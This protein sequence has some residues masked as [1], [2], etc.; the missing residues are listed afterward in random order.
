MNRARKHH[1][2]V[3]VVEL[4]DRVWNEPSF[5]KANPGYQLSK[6]LLYVRMTG[7]DPDSPSSLNSHRSRSRPQGE[8]M[9]DLQLSDVQ[10][11]NLRLLQAIRLGLERDR[12]TTCCKFALDAE[13]AER[14]RAQS[15]E[16]LMSFVT[17]VNRLRFEVQHS[18][19]TEELHY[20]FCLLSARHRAANLY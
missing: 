11:T 10:S 13:L 12:V 2:H 9:N 1:H 15:L 4:S 8:T 16:Q 3:Y 17:H 5:R 14:L 6:P 20:G 19:F 18:T 7:L